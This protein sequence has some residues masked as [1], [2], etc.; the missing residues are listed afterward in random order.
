MIGTL[1]TTPAGA[2]RVASIGFDWLFLDGEHGTFDRRN[3]GPAIASVGA[4]AR[5]YVRLAARD[6]AALADAALDA[7]AAG[8]IVPLVNSA[9]E[10][11]R[12]VV[13]VRGRG[14]VVVQAETREAVACIA[15]IARVS[16]LH[17]ILIGPNDLSASLGIPGQFA[18]AE[19]LRSVRAIAD[20]CHAAGVAKGIYGADAAAVEAHMASGFTFIVAG[21]NLPMDA[22][23]ALLHLL[24]TPQPQAC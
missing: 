15:E 1:V 18:H 4:R 16:G 7:G 6:D 14:S 17:A 24:R 20:G 13:L 22:A 8:V 10:A 9:E 3:V 11:A 21:K 12:A 2:A 19:F 23:R 5:C